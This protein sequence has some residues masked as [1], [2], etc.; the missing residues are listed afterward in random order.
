MILEIQKIQKVVD[1][2]EDTIEIQLIVSVT[3]ENK[4]YE[5]SLLINT[6]LTNL[7]STIT[8]VKQLPQQLNQCSHY[9]RHPSYCNNY[10]P[11]QLHDTSLAL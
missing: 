8:N 7:S 10:F 11:L 2:Q 1:E 9:D 6:S 5:R 4:P 3:F